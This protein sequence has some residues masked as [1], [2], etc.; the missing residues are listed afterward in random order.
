MLAANQ[1]VSGRPNEWFDT[2]LNRGHRSGKTIFHRLD[3][4]C[5]AV[6][7]SDADLALHVATP[8]KAVDA[9]CAFT[10]IF[11]ESSGSG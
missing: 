9:A 8:E 10:L 6:I 1:D 5:A 7:E 11:K 4:G 3:D 2:A